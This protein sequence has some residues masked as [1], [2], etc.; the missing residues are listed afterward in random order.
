MGTQVDDIPQ[1]REVFY[2]PYAS[3]PTSGVK[4]SDLAFA[5]DRK[6]LYRWNGSSWDAL[7]IYSGAGLAADI[8][9]AADLPEGSLY[10]E[11]DTT[12]LKQVQSA[13]WQQVTIR[14][15]SGSYTGDATANRAIPH[16]LGITPKIV[17]ISAT[18]GAFFFR[19]ITGLAKIIYINPATH[20]THTVSVINNTNFYVGNSSDYTQSANFT[21]ITYYWVAIG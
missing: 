7:T 16:G 13:A 4:V 21:T 10:F 17:F 8:P 9:N 5:T 2:A 20:G 6:I 11:T 1:T 19:I 3:F 12:K 18:S 15:S 14:T